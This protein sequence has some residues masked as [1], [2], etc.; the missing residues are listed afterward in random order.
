MSWSRL[1]A[2]GVTTGLVAASLVSGGV[3]HVPHVQANVD[4]PVRLGYRRRF[5]TLLGLR[6]IL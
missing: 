6:K 3:A 2:H 1:V 5:A 4:G